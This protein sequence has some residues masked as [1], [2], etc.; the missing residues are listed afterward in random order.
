MIP[1]LLH[2]AGVFCHLFFVLLFFVHCSFASC[3][4][5]I[6]VLTCEQPF[7][8]VKFVRGEWGKPKTL[9]TARAASARGA[10]MP[11]RVKPC[12]V[13]VCINMCNDRRISAV[14]LNKYLPPE[15][16]FMTLSRQLAQSMSARITCPLR[17]YMRNADTR[18]RGRWQNAHWRARRYAQIVYCLP[19]AAMA[20]AI[21]PGF[22][23]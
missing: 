3:I 14:M 7:A 12:Y 18:R 1:V 21:V 9:Q 23:M 2:R 17:L 8:V 6:L 19:S 20:V 22:N 15:C 11:A 16:A 5:P 13:C 4:T 10:T